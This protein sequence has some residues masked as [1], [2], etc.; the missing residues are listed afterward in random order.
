M[1]RSTRR[2][3]A[4]RV[5]GKRAH[6]AGRDFEAELDHGNAWYTAQRWCKLQKANAQVRVTKGET[7]LVGKGGVDRVGVFAG[8]PIAFEAKNRTGC[9]SFALLDRKGRDNEAKELRDL[10]EFSRAGAL[11]FYLVRDADLMRVYAIGAEHFA[12]L[13]SGYSV[14]L[15]EDVRRGVAAHV[16]PRAL[17]PA[18]EITESA[19]VRALASGKP[20]WE[21]PRLFPRE[22]PNQPTIDPMP[23]LQFQSEAFR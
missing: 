20:I 4:S 1:K 3:V 8:V 19:R 18:L 12:M 7:F 14:R 9:A 5:G 17:V 22:L 11:A 15:R 16:P 23:A 10:I 2:A 13:E 6:D 21:W